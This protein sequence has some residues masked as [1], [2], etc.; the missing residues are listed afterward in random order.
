L[1][2][3]EINTAEQRFFSQLSGDLTRLALDISDSAQATFMPLSNKG[4]FDAVLLQ[5]TAALRPITLSH[6][7]GA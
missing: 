2:L 5:R 4:Y 7:K 3:H 1:A 6:F